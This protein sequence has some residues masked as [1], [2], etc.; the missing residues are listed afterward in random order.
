MQ[1]AD[2]ADQMLVVLGERLYPGHAQAGKVIEERARREQSPHADEKGR[3]DQEHQP[4]PEAVL[5]ALEIRASL[6][7]L[8]GIP[9]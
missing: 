7:Y 6:G 9:R 3:H 4:Q 2:V 1:T 8:Q 5:L